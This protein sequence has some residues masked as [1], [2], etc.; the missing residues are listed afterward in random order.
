MCLEQCLVQQGSR[1]ESGGHGIPGQFIHA[2]IV[3]DKLPIQNP[4]LCSITLHKKQQLLLSFTTQEC[5]QGDSGE[6][7]ISEAFSFQKLPEPQTRSETKRYATARPFSQP[8]LSNPHNSLGL[9]DQTFTFYLNHDCFL[10]IKLQI[11][12]FCLLLL[13]VNKRNLGNQYPSH[14]FS[15]SQV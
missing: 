12:C 1:I 15:P 10:C 13:I 8:L 2:T 9:M 5:S 3:M 11:K 7:V 14:S 4:Q 6:E